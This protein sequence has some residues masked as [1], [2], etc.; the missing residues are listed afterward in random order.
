MFLPGSISSTR[1]DIRILDEAEAE[2]ADAIARYESI[3]SG[4]GVR[5]KQKVK[6]AIAWVSTRSG[7]PRFR[8][9]GY[10]RVNLRIFP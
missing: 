2:F 3:E 6:S 4:L 1:H 8:P 5:L 10:R 9:Q 7:L